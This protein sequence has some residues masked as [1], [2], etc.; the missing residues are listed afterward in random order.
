MNFQS[1][2]NEKY[3][4]PFKLSE[5]KNSLDKCNDTTA[6]P[7]GIHYQIL[8]HLLSDELETLLNIINEIWRT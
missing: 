1:Q 8:K 3:S 6:G 7:D 2:N 5:L 4:L